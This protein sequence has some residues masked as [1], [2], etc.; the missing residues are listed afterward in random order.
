MLFIFYAIVKRGHFRVL[1]SSGVTV[2]EVNEMRKEAEKPASPTPIENLQSAPF[3]R[4]WRR[5]TKG[6]SNIIYVYAHMCWK[7]CLV[8]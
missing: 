2:E 5:P 4:R 3:L 6:V 7:D 1:C 8:V